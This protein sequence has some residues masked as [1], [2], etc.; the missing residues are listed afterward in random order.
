MKRILVILSLLLTA[1]LN[2]QTTNS[3]LYT[4]DYKL[5]LALHPKMASY[6]MVLERHLRSDLNFADMEKLN[7]I[8]MQVASL[9]I[10][11]N[12]RTEKL[13]RDL[14]KIAIEL[15]RIENRMSGNTLEFDEEKKQFDGDNTQ[16]S[17]IVKI[18][19]LQAQRRE[20]ENQI[21]KVWDDVMNPLYLT[22]GQTK[23]IVD[24]VISEID[25][26]LENFSRQLGGAVI[27]DSDYQSVQFAP[28]RITSSP[29]VGASPL[30]VRL[31]QSLLNS[32]LI[33]DVP[34]VYKSDPELSRYASSMR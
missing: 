18:T 14:D 24:G 12:R 9:S 25:L 2:A 17:Q 33:G 23:Q 16:R 3:G 27:L 4:V 15:S 8:N 13:T 1:C 26:L 5:L 11:A 10:E 31:Y 32:D 28:Q 20:I 34:D 7:A 29:A 21:V 30:S 22:K 19:Q 6:D